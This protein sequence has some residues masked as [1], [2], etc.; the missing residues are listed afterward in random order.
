MA[1]LPTLWPLVPE[2]VRLSAMR[3][4]AQAPLS[5]GC[6][7]AVLRS[8]CATSAVTADWHQE[9]EE[10]AVPL[11]GLSVPSVRQGSQRQDA[12]ASQIRGPHVKLPVARAS[13]RNHPYRHS[14]RHMQDEYVGAQAPADEDTW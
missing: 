4:G 7:S 3:E 12:L 9:A 14:A 1:K 13:T 6:R 10:Y 8:H 11:Q 5:Q 2:E